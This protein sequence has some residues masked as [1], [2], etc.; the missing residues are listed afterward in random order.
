MGVEV[1]LQVLEGQSVVEDL[2]DGQPS[3]G[4]RDA[5]TY[6]SVILEAVGAAT[7]AV[8]ARMVA[9]AVN[10]ILTDWVVVWLNECGLVG[11]FGCWIDCLKVDEKKRMGRGLTS[12]YT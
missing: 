8:A 6:T 12:L 5:R 11:K 9:A 2:T 7:A 1:V 3:R 10:F 4:A